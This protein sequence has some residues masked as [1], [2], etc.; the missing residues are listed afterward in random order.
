[1]AQEIGREYA[2]DKVNKDGEYIKIGGSPVPV[3]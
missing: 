1:M 3:H 2:P